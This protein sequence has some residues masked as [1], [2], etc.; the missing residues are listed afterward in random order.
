MHRRTIATL[1]GAVLSMGMLMAQAQQP[2]P[3]QQAPPPDAS[4]PMPPPPPHRHMNPKRQMRHL[5]RV[6]NL[7]P[8]QQAQIRPIVED[9]DKALRQVWNDTSLTPQDRRA[10]M[11]DANQEFRSRMEAVLSDQQ[12]QAFEAMLEGQREH[13]RGGPPAAPPQS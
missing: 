6:L 2:A 13:R 5:T 3:D 12:K 11:R 9:H 1:L 10:R 8:E 7:S 4:Q